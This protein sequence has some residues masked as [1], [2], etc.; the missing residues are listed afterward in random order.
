[1]GETLARHPSLD[2]RFDPAIRIVDSD[3]RWPERAAAELR[4]IA[5][6]LG[7]LAVRLEHVG[8]TAVPGLAAKPII[9]L[10]LSVAAI[11]PRGAYLEPLE[12]L[13]YLFV[14]APESPDYHFF[15]K[16]P[17]RPRVFHLHVGAAG[18]EHEFRHL[19]VRDYLIAHLEEAASY[20]ALK[21]DVAG[22]H[23]QDRLAYIEGKG[24]YV[25]RLEARAL[26]WARG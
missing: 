8:S 24:D 13:G 26:A 2:D 6:A 5:D 3:P 7:P 12:R 19:A 9:D 11:D 16:P 23:P 15:A 4:H 20:A 18:S 17:E 21:R 22:R 14:P 25:T 10:Q 1:V